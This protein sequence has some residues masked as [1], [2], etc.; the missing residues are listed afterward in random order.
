MAQRRCLIGFRKGP[1]FLTVYFNLVNRQL[2]THTDRWPGALISSFSIPKYLN[3]KCRS[4][5]NVLN[6]RVYALFPNMS[7]VQGMFTLSGI[8]GFKH[9]MQW[10][11]Q[12]YSL[13]SE[14]G[15]NLLTASREEEYI[16]VTPKLILVSLGLVK[17]YLVGQK[18][19]WISCVVLEL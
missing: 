3:F 8:L 12:R 5:T 16:T 19:I 2:F 18:F 9:N 14:E 1:W 17:I 15:W 7:C 6:L 10:K 13:C 4:F 11:F